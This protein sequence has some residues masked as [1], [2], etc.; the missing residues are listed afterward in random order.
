MG[1]QVVEK[2]EIKVVGIPWSGTYTEINQLPFLFDEMKQRLRDVPYQ[3]NEPILIAPFHGRETELTYYFTTPVSEIKEIPEGMVGFTIPRKFY[4]CTTH[5]GRQDE[6]R[7]TY[8][9]LFNWMKEYGY[10]QDFHA[11]SLEVFHDVYS[12]LDESGSRF[13]DIYVPLKTYNRHIDQDLHF[14]STFFSV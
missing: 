5:S 2:G 3:T 9:Q 7:H 14:Q 4:V 11:L 1:M 12:L 13:F 6:I 10:E 8:Q